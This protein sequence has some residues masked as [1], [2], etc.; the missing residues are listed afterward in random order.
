MM[1]APL[2]VAQ[3]YDSGIGQGAG[4]ESHGESDAASPESLSV[5]LV[6]ITAPSLLRR[7]HVLC[8]GVS[9]HDGK[10]AGGVQ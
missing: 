10:A 4:L 9:V 6:M 5:E 1:N 7:I 3:S 8:R 2:S